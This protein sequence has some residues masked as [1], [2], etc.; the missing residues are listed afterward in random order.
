[1]VIMGVSNSRLLTSAAS[2]RDRPSRIWRATFSTTTMASSTTS[3]TDST[4]ASVVSRFREKPISDIQAMAPRMEIGMVSSGT[5][6][7]RN[8]PMSAST[9]RP[10]S[11]MVSDRVV[12]ISRRASRM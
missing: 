7:V 10:T 6:A 8:E 11:K 3:P 5:S 9:T 2:V 1:M 12:K 4:M